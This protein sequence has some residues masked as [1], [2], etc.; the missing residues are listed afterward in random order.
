MSAIWGMID[1]SCSDIEGNLPDIM[2]G[3][4]NKYKIDAVNCLVEG[5]V[6]MACGL[7]CFTRE[8]H[9]EILPISDNGMFFTADCILDDRERLV[10]ELQE[11][12]NSADL[13][14][15][16]SKILNAPS[17]ISGN[18]PDG[19]L[20]YMAYRLWGKRFAD[21]VTGQFS[22]ACYD[23]TNGY[24]SVYTDHTASRCI[25]YHVAGNKVYFATLT[26]CITDVEKDISLCDRW[27]KESQAV[28]MG[29]TYLQEG[30]TPFEGVFILPYGTGVDMCLKGGKVSVDRHRY[31]DP[32]N[33]IK[34][35]S[36]FDDD[37]C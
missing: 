3:C 27:M 16:N 26:A 24:I 19:T 21:H 6:Y 20:L 33:S 4:I 15:Y 30:Y 35:N 17:A 31:W 2:S 12:A 5:N 14:E 28:E 34:R 13:S 10:S 23:R 9:D 32:L 11:S 7:Q 18:L 22:F 36:S 1:L 8:S 29:Y 37:S 25:H